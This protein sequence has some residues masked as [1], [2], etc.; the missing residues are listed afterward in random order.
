MG[1]GNSSQPSSTQFIAV[2]LAHPSQAAAAASILA[3]QWYGGSQSS[4]SE[5]SPGVDIVI[6]NA[7]VFTGAPPGASICSLDLHNFFTQNLFFYFYSKCRSRA[8]LGHKRARTCSHIP[9]DY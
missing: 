4:S 5:S 8:H 3:G 1:R 6:N 2:D 9:C 7:G